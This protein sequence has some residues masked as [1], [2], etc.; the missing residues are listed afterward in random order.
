MQALGR[1][2]RVRAPHVRAAGTAFLLATG[3]L[4]SACSM[5]SES[6]AGQLRL[7][8]LDGPICASPSGWCAFGAASGDLDGNVYIR[9]TNVVAALDN[10]GKDVMRLAGTFLLSSSKGQLQ[11][12]LDGYMDAATGRIRS[13]VDLTQGTRHYHK[14]VGILSLWGNANLES[15][16]E[17]DGYSGGLLRE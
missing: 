9:F 7:R 3:L 13:T 17:E 6:V 10:E 4:L 14:N 11:G 8:I 16:L 2:L 1:L 5:G 15:R 12:T